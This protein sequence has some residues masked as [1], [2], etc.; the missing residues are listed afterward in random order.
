MRA[1]LPGD[2]SKTISAKLSIIFIHALGREV[3][4]F[5]GN[6]SQQCLEILQHT[7]REVNAPGQQTGEGKFRVRMKGRA[8]G[9]AL[10]SS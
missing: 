8:E 4:E 6:A 2:L 5:M 1:S 3:S 10:F 7:G 9:E